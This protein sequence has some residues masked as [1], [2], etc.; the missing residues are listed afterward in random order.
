M[1]IVKKILKSPVSVPL[2]ALILISLVIGSTTDVFWQADNM[3]N[4]VLQVGI[5]SIMSV[6]A[7]FVILTGGIDLSP[8]SAMCLL[9][10]ILAS[11]VKLQG[12]PTIIGVIIVLI[13][14]ILL[15]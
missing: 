13:I 7:T 5:V 2:M 3:R 9:T 4:I 8:G 6:G 11:T 1:L 15:A 14:G 10:M 12:L